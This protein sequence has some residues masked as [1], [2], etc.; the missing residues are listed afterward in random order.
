MAS[1]KQHFVADMIINTATLSLIYYYPNNVYEIIAANVIGT[2]LTPDIDSESGTYNEILIANF[3]KRILVMLG[4]RR[5]AAQKDTAI[6]YRIQSAVTAPYG[7]LIPH[8]SWLS[9]APIVGTIT[10]TFYL[11]LLYYVSG[12]IMSFP[13][14]DYITLVKNYQIGMVIIMLHHII[15]TAMDGFM[16]IFMG[17][18]MYLLGYPFYYMTTKFFPQGD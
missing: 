12:K 3:V 18:K 2:L 14:L 1:G 4:R 9:H 8:R 5:L 13:I 6:I 17:R 15:H 7:V 16:I 11:W 10:I